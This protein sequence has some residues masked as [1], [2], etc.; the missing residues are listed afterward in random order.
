MR[1]TAFDAK[2]SDICEVALLP[3]PL[4]PDKPSNLTLFTTLRNV[5]R[6]KDLLFC[7][8]AQHTVITT[9]RYNICR[10]RMPSSGMGEKLVEYWMNMY[11]YM[12]CAKYNLCVKTE[13]VTAGADV[14]VYVR[15]FCIYCTIVFTVN[16]V[17][18]PDIEQPVAIRSVCTLSEDSDCFWDSVQALD[19]LIMENQEKARVLGDT[20]AKINIAYFQVKKF[21][22]PFAI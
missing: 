13:P 20:K 1:S 15:L 22:A 8:A 21:V 5:V 19:K 18:K 16:L 17:Q 3:L 6:S 4:P 10:C 12:H 14:S 2:A 11:E 9:S 7:V